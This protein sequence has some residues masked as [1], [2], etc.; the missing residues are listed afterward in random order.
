MKPPRNTFDVLILGSGAAGLSCAL[1]LPAGLRVAVLAK[2]GIDEGNT[3]WAQ[4]GI[5]AVL[6]PGDDVESHI[7]D[8]LDAG[9][10]LP[11]R[12]VVT[13]VASEG[14]EVIAW[15]ERLGMPFT[16]ENGKPHLTREGGHSHRRVVHAQDAT[17]AALETTLLKTHV[18]GRP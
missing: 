14:A 13:R 4:G 7:E 15:L 10:A 16:R 1:N 5:A 17:G 9:A 18:H 3:Q 6:D 8:T 11:D 2:N 12:D